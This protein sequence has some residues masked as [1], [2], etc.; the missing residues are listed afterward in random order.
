MRREIKINETSKANDDLK[1]DSANANE[2][3]IMRKE[4]KSSICERQRGKRE[5]DKKGSLGKQ[6]QMVDVTMRQR[7]KENEEKGKVEP[8]EENQDGGHGQIETENI[9]KQ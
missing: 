5:N 9:I 8:D 4:K 7:Q 3:K 6:H 1:E 2:G